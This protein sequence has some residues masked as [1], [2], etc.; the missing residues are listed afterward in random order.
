MDELLFSEVQYPDWWVF[1]ILG[2]TG[3]VLPTLFVALARHAGGKQDKRLAAG[4]LLVAAA[5]T[6]LLSAGMAAA[7]GRLSTDVTAEQV[8]V[9]F[10]WVGAYSREVPL[11]DIQGAAD[12]VTYRP[13]EHGGWGIRGTSQDRI[14]SQKGDEGVRLRLKDGGSLLIGSQEAKELA[15]ALNKARAAGGAA[16]AAQ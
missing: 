10:G 7:F 9:S 13:M 15:A 1:L 6:F 14:L 5:L 16:A 3:L 2:F 4:A 12:A 8:R 11:G